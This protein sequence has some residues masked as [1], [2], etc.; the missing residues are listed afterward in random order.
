MFIN[1]IGM[2]KINKILLYNFKVIIWEKMKIGV[3]NIEL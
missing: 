1:M 3:R 2:I